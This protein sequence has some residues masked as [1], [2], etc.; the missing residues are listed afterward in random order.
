MKPE[1]LDKLHIGQEWFIPMVATFERFDIST[2]ERQAGFI[3][4]CQHESGNFR[5]VRENL[6]YSARALRSIFGKHRITDAECEKYGRTDDHPA[7]KEMIAN[8][9]YGGDWGAKN[10]G[11]TEPGDGWQY[12]GRGVIQLTGRANYQRLSDAVG[13]D[14]ISNPHFLE[15]PEYAILSAGWFWDSRGLNKYADD[16]DW[17]TL[18]KRINGGTIGLEDRVAHIESAL[19]VLKA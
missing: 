9:I 1:Q 10:L 16:K 15:K 8:T 5:R 12:S 2:P 4:Q 19:Q 13:V 14:F 18:T 6:N 7:D 11:N 17:L 3:G